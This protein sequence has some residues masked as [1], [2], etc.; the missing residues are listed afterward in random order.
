M[1]I[2]PCTADAY[3]SSIVSP[4]GLATFITQFIYH[5]LI[6]IQL[7]AYLCQRQT[8]VLLHFHTQCIAYPNLML[9]CPI[10][11]LIS[12]IS[13]R[14]WKVVELP[15]CFKCKEQSDNIQSPVSGSPHLTEEERSKFCYLIIFIA[16]LFTVQQLPA[17]Y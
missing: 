9:K 12:V 5:S 17:T 16:T 6:K 11:S 14:G 4:S 10:V 3:N 7:C 1:V 8:M 15:N 13:T 2:T